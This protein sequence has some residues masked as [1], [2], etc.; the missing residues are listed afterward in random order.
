M[1]SPTV[2]ALG[3]RYQLE[4][5]LGSGA[6]GQV[7]RARDLRSGEAVAAKLLREEFTADPQIVGRFVQERSIL[8][9]LVHPH[10]VAVRDL[11]V[12]GGDLGIVMD[13]VVGE[14]LRAHLRSRSTLPPAEAVR[15]T[16]DVLDALATAHAR[17]VLHRDVKPDNVLLD[18]ADPPFVRLS[19]FGIARLAQETT[20]RM[21]GVLGTAEYIAPEVFT[22]E[23]VS[24]AA[25]VYGAGVQLYELLAGRT[26]FAGGG[27]SYAVAF[28]HVTTPPPELPGLPAALASTLGQMLAKDPTDRPSATA[29]AAA[30][31][32]T[33]P[34]LAGLAALPPLAEPGWH[35][36]PVAPGSV[37]VRGGSGG[38]THDAQATALKGELI[39]PAPP[40]PLAA[41]QSGAALPPAASAEALAAHTQLQG[42]RIARPVVD[43]P[44]GPGAAG[45]AH[46]RRRRTAL[47]AAAVVV[48][49]V[50]LGGG[51]YALFGHSSGGHAAPKAAPITQATGSAPTENDPIGLSIARSGVYSSSAKSLTVTLTY[52][53]MTATLPGPFFEVIPPVTAGGTCPAVTWTGASAVRDTTEGL[54]DPGCGWQVSTG[55][56]AQGASVSATYAM[57]FTLPTGNAPD[58]TTTYVSGEA[59]ATSTALA[60]LTSGVAYPAQ[61]LASVQ[62]EV[63]QPIVRKPIT[64]VAYPVWTGS[65]G[66][67]DTLDAIYS[68][69]SPTAASSLATALGGVSA[70]YSMTCAI[71]TNATS[72]VAYA[73]TPQTG[74]TLTLDVGGQPETSDS[75]DITTPG[76]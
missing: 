13:L 36:A 48:V 29:A 22:A 47:I 50:V 58:D 54:D 34:G 20:V 5:V 19:D 59:T 3:S 4:E 64:I 23:T 42:P 41:P 15:I 25:D 16:V 32:A 12:D 1:S 60:N 44:A 18:A 49:L 38:V 56:V 68:S 6:M 70:P 21:T 27:T 30:L 69:A 33:A 10:I 31:R 28:R 52:S 11:V 2:R 51:G 65:S 66:S 24:A 35:D 63:T 61:R 40:R 43:V 46:D 73:E 39:A 26:P 17:G 8:I 14:D 67:P 55:P 7:W 75:F 76:G 37:E 74:C 9:E 62:V 72:H 53:S 71:N 57:P 45:P